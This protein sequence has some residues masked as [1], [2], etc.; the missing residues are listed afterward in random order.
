MQVHLAPE[1]IP[2]TG[3]ELRSHW[4]L[5]TFGVPGDAIVAFLGPCEVDPAAMV[6]LEDVLVGAAIRA[7]LMLHF[8]VE[9]FDSGLESAVL[10]QRLLVALAA[11]ALA[12]RGAQAGPGGLR[13]AGDDLFIG[14]RKLSVSI[15]TVSPVST[16]I[17]L[18]I[19]VNPEGAPVPA[20]GLEELGVEPTGFARELM[21]ALVQEL[22]GVRA[23]RC[24]VRAVP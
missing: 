19:N 22:D 17:H 20:V 7:R 21:A 18:G 13:R 9:S 3:A 10:V 14:E 5:R 11:E 24:K 12:R 1:Q 8:V 2:Y 4:I 6:D 15:A 23:A 16:L